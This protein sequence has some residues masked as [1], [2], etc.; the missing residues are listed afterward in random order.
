MSSLKGSQV[1]ISKLWSISGIKIC[2]NFT[3]STD[4]DEMTHHVIF[5]LGIHYFQI[6]RMETA[7][8]NK[9]SFSR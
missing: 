8:Q 2:F 1:E 5:N 9:P 7:K 4:P 6:F 3:N